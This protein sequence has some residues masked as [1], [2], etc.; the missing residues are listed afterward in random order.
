MNKKNKK[1]QFYLRHK[2]W[3]EA[4]LE[5]LSSESRSGTIASKN[6]K[7]ITIPIICQGFTGRRP[8]AKKNR[9]FFFM[10][11]PHPPS[12]VQP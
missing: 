8:S 5:Q 6:Q 11:Q 4:N 2:N 9:V 3:N 7:R 1:A 12:R 10:P